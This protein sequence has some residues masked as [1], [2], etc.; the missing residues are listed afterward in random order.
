TDTL[1]ALVSSG[2]NINAISTA[3]PTMTIVI[4]YMSNPPPKMYTLLITK[5]ELF[6][7]TD[8]PPIDADILT[9][10]TNR[11][12]S[13]LNV[14]IGTNSLGIFTWNN[15]NAQPQN[16]GVHSCQWQLGPLPNLLKREHP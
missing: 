7:L 12:L 13:A 15:L 14:M 9:P 11:T 4:T 6:D 1:A 5:I 3:Y 10:A 2:I 16:T 8:C